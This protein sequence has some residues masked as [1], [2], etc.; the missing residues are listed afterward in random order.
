MNSFRPSSSRLAFLQAFPSSA[1]QGPLRVPSTI[2]VRRDGVSAI[3]ILN[4][5]LYSG[6]SIANRLPNPSF[7]QPSK[8]LNLLPAGN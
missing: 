4:T 1:T 6:L 8:L 7:R 3:E 2:S 5:V